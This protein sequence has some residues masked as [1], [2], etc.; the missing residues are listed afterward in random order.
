M[1]A[2][3]L[4]LPT[5]ILSDG[6]E[7]HRPAQFLPQTVTMDTPAIEVMTDLQKVTAITIEPNVS[8]NDANQKMIAN[9]VRLLLVTHTGNT[10]E[11]LI[12]ASDILGEKP[13]IY[14]R[15]TGCKLAEIRVEDIMTLR[16]QL[17]VMQLVDVNQARV[18]NIVE[19]LKRQGRQHA[20]VV[21]VDEN[22]L[23]ESLRGIFSCAQISKQLGIPVET[24]GKANTFAELEQALFA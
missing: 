14:A 3:Y 17:E 21:D 15:K 22:T 1:A 12:T 5:R 7:F 13:M 9:K 16:S 2:N 10:I 11:G 18:G 19:S 24:S 20:L 8:L 4:P 23:H 6:A